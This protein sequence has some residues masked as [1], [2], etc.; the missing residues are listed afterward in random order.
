[1]G[2]V[3]D[4]RTIF[5]M[6]DDSKQDQLQIG[7]ILLLS[8]FCTILLQCQFFKITTSKPGNFCISNNPIEI[9]ANTV[10]V[11]QGRLDCQSGDYLNGMSPLQWHGSIPQ[12]PGKTAFGQSYLSLRSWKLINYYGHHK[13]FNELTRS[14]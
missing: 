13:G 12:N 14:H 2:R 11:W 7:E 8:H 4:G 10:N 3:N 6:V 1:M 5:C 9:R